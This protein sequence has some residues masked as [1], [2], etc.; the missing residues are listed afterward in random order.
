MKEAFL[1]LH[2]AVLIAGTTGLFGKLITLGEFPLTFYRVGFAAIMFWIFM[3]LTGKVHRMPFNHILKMCGVGLLLALHWVFF[4]GSIKY[5]NISIGV[6]CFSL[7]GFF[8]AIFEPVIIRRRPSISELLFSL[9]TV[10]GIVLIFHF[11]SRY[12]F[13]IMLGII[14]SA[15]NAL[16]TIT[17]K[18]TSQSTGHSSSTILLYAMTGGAIGMAVLLP[19]FVS[20]CPDARILPTMSDFL[21]LLALSS[22]STLL[23]YL[24]QIQTLKKV[25]AFTV[26][27]TFNLEPIYS[28]IMAMLFFG[29][30]KQL[31]LSFYA[32]LLLIFLSVALQTLS[33]TRKTK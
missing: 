16:F 29:E 31:N 17:N 15:L 12:R 10:L 24:L 33:V 3:M 14:S 11:D 32:G 28:I 20:A 2:I 23:L 4:Y 6:V 9:L 8:T 26:S 7:V 18:L 19:F 30:A 5:S 27:L 21:W 1:K 22:V 13:G 25:S